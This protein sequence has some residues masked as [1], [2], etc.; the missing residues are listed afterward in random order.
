MTER[1]FDT[2][3]IASRWCTELSDA[4]K[5]EVRELARSAAE[6]DAEMGFSQL[7]FADR[8]RDDRGSVGHVLVRALPHRAT[9]DTVEGLP[10]VGYVGVYREPES[11]VATLELAIRPEF[12]S[13][14]VA[15]LVFE[16]LGFTV[17]DGEGWRGT[18]A[19]TLRG[20][21]RGTHPAADRLAM[22]FGASPSTRSWRLTRP[23]TKHETDR[24]DTNHVDAGVEVHASVSRETATALIGSDLAADPP[25][26][27]FVVRNEAAEIAGAL[28]VNVVVS[29]EGATEAEIAQFNLD[30]AGAEGGHAD[31]LLAVA[32]DRLSKA[33][34]TAAVI[35]VD[36]LEGA[37]PRLLRRHDFRHDQTDTWFEKH[38]GG[39]VRAPA[40]AAAA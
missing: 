27:L 3:M 35:S 28:A 10:L 39:P 4:E 2:Y 21:A 8:N 7:S 25:D 33:D 11:D 24:G 29:D 22:R 40:A 16:Q 30:P 32:C 14:G 13:R 5:D 38:L 1:P 26:H 37:V 19:I 15:T 6:F 31:R 23:L 34:I 18:G 9:A 12:R 36:S 17:S 20:I